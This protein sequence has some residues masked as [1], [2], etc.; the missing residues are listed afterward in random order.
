MADDRIAEVFAEIRAK[1]MRGLDALGG[2]SQ[3]RI[4]TSISV[5][6]KRD[7]AGNVTERSAP[8][9]PPRLDTGEL[10][11]N[12]EHKTWDHGNIVGVTVGVSKPDKPWVPV[13]LEE[14]TGRVKRRPFMRP[15]MDRLQGG[16]GTEVVIEALE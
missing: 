4:E 8:N 13:E 6:V 10:H 7:A 3:T 12:V 16:D 2:L 15:E 9:Q 11:G 5:P 14:G 1:M